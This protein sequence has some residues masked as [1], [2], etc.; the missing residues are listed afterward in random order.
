MV[1][2]PPVALPLQPWRVM[3]LRQRDRVRSRAVREVVTVTIPPKSCCPCGKRRYLSHLEATM[4][5]V[6]IR[7]W[8]EER[9]RTPC[10]V[11]ECHLC[12]G[13]FHLTSQ[14]LRFAEADA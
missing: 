11:Y 4:A 14:P 3:H 2:R 6:R 8:G 9:E 13:G 5:L 7:E 12:G 10:R 1:A